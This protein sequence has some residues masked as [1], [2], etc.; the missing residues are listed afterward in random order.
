MC[1]SLDVAGGSWRSHSTL[2]NPR[3]SS[4]A[5]TLSSGTYIFGGYTSP[6][7]SDYLPAASKSWQA[8][9]TIPGHGHWRGCGVK[10]SAT[11]LLLIGGQQESLAWSNQVIKYTE[12]EGWQEMPSLNQIPIMPSCA[13][14]GNNVIVASGIISTEIIPLD[15]Y[16]PRTGGGLLTHRIGHRLITVG[17]LYPRLLALGGGEEDEN[18]A[19]FFSS[20]EEWDEVKEQ[21]NISPLKLK[22]PNSS[23]GALALP[24]STICANK[25]Y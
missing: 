25:A 17:G 8:G 7:T 9:P 1:Y 21:W 11:E 14:I 15:T 18:G 3:P 10:V 20:I 12:S 13:V 19:N 6:T 5:I 23:F 16:Q 4:T 22:I 2:I 24:P